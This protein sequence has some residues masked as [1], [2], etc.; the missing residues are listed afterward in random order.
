M[1]HPDRR[2]IGQLGEAKNS[3]RVVNGFPRSKN[4]TDREFF[5]ADAFEN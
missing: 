5:L 3:V 1:D 4:I 2:S